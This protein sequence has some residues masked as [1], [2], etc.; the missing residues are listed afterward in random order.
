MI[1]SRVPHPSEGINERLVHGVQPVVG[2]SYIPGNLGMADFYGQLKEETIYKETENRNIS[3]WP[4]N[5]RPQRNT[6]RGQ[7]NNYA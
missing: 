5:F 2:F 3:I 4:Q 1:P 6:R 7:M